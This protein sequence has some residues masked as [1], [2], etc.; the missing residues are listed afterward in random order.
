MSIFNTRD[1]HKDNILEYSKEE[2]VYDDIIID[3]HDSLVLDINKYDITN[4]YILFFIGEYY[5]HKNI[6]YNEMIKYYLMAIDKDNINA[7]N[8]LAMHYESI[9]DYDNTVKYYLMAI[10][11][12]CSSAMNNLGYYY[13]Y[14]E[15]DHDEMLKYFLMAIEYGNKTAMKNLAIYYSLISDFDNAKK[16]TLMG[17]M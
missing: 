12:G 9:E 3:I 13:F 11:K 6:N 2:K 17:K 1:I 4:G 14:Y 10:D 7:M 8:N 15:A 16:Y 5:E